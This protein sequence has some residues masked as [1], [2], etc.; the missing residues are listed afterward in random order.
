MF[1]DQRVN[2]AN[3][4]AREAAAALVSNW[5]KPKLRDPVLPLNV[6]VG[7]FVAV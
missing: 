1:F 6:Y 3:L 4:L 5:T 7:R 2:P